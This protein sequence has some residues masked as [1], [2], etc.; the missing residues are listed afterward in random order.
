MRKLLNKSYHEEN[1]KKINLQAKYLYLYVI[2]V[3]CVVC[4]KHFR[5]IQCIAMKW[6]GLLQ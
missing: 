4:L 2:A 5:S 6:L 1:T 3:L